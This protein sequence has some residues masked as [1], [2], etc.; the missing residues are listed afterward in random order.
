MVWVGNRGD[1]ERSEEIME[2]FVDPVA[3]LRLKGSVYGVRYPGRR[4]LGCRR[5][6]HPGADR[7]NSKDPFRRLISKYDLVLT[8][9][10]GLPIV[11]AYCGFGARACVPI[12]MHGPAPSNGGEGRIRKG[13]DA[14]MPFNV[15][16]RGTP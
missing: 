2:F 14:V 13:W 9:G 16:D 6:R 8:Y 1:E 10:G 5:P 7:G 3:R 11:R 15:I 4:L 12:Y